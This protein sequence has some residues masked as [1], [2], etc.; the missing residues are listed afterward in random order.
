[1]IAAA[2]A[3]CVPAPVC[4]GSEALCDAPLAEVTLP[5]AHNALSNAED[6]WI[7][8]NQ[9]LSVAHPLESGVRV[10]VFDTRPG[11]DGLPWLCHG[12]CSLGSRPLVDGLRD[13]TDA[14][15]SGAQWPTLGAL[16]ALNG[17]AP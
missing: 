1:M 6:G 12:D 7:A 15:P 2:L 8:P 11:G 4:N 14:H 9:E 5:G 17:D 10:V 13:L 16:I 3:A